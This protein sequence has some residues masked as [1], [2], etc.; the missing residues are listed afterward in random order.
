MAAYAAAYLTGTAPLAADALTVSPYLG[1]GSLTPALDVALAEGRGLFVLALTS[2]PEGRQ[3]QHA[4]T[5]GIS[6]GTAE[7]TVAQSIIDQVGAVNAGDYPIGSIGLV[8][9]ATIGQT[10]VD[11]S[12]VNGPLLAPGLGAQGATAADL[13]FVFAD[14]HGALLPTTSRGVL[15]AGPSVAGLREAAQ[16][17]V[18]EVRAALG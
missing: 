16:R 15:G 14:A 8:I 7:K 11:L 10:G 6:D 5:A 1:F 9:G 13:K 4:R 12:G 3:V 18:D 2:N 17:T